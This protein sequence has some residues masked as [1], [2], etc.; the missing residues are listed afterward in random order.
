LDT[1]IPIYAIFD[2]F[3]VEIIQMAMMAFFPDLPAA[4]SGISP[5]IHIK[6]DISFGCA[7]LHPGLP[8]C[9]SCAY[10]KACEEGLNN[11]F[12]ALRK[13]PAPI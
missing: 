6:N 11:Y 10:S 7:G 5:T 3:W 4:T 13:P 2:V 1:W 12:L 8:W 9:G